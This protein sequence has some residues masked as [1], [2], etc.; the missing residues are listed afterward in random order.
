MSTPFTKGNPIWLATQDPDDPLL[1][2]HYRRSVLYY[3]K[4]YQAWPCWADEDK[5]TALYKEAARRR[6]EGE[7][8]QVDHQVPISHPHVSG[9]HTYTN[10][11][12]LGTR[13]NLIK[14]NHWWPD[15]WDEQLTLEL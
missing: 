2:P 6:K 7:E 8:V 4:L 10:L 14:G 11:A 9:L 1:N 12:I 13:A 3:R 15:M 5:M